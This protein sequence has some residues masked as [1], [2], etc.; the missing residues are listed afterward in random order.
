MNTMIQSTKS[1]PK[2]TP[3]VCQV[4]K[5]NEVE[6]RKRSGLV[7]ASVALRELTHNRNVF[8]FA[9]FFSSSSSSAFWSGRVLFLLPP[10]L[11]SSLYFSSLSLYYRCTFSVCFEEWRTLWS[12]CGGQNQALS[13]GMLSLTSISFSRLCPQSWDHLLGLTVHPALGL[14]KA[15]RSP[16][17]D[18]QVVWVQREAERCSRLVSFVCLTKSQWYCL[19]KQSER[20]LQWKRLQ[21]SFVECHVS[22]TLIQ[23]LEV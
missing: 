7:L 15:D 6:K 9:S 17:T 11:C 4:K 10:F 1:F 18:P 8:P 22:C 20:T 14:Q 13:L 23:M 3:C 21:I 5:K 2:L 12:H 19:R 16:Q